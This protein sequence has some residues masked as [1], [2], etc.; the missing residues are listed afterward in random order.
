MSELWPALLFAGLGLGALWLLRRRALRMPPL[1]RRWRELLAARLTHYSKLESPLRELFERHVQEFLAGKRFYGCGGLAVSDEMR[2]LIAGM[3]C[4]L[5]L[6]P[7]ARV[8]PQLRSVL[9]YPTAFWVRHEE[10]DDIGLVYDEDILQVGESQEWGRVVLSWEDVQAALAG[11]AV[12]V[13]AHE[14]AH[15]LDEGEG[16]PA[17]S[18]YHRW[19]QV[20]K[21]AYGELC[22]KGSPVL[23]D[24]GAQ[25]PAEF[26]ALATE[27]YF[28]RG[29]E[30]RKHHTALYALLKEFYLL[31]TA[32]AS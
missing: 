23:D 22:E 11:D 14:F 28:Q 8:F 15:Q 13:V 17:L 29:A 31:D 5:L 30:L 24:Y 6:R 4:L 19:S 9:L 16:A 1:P 2:V 21:D 10:P 20:M 3:A 18:E 12:N 26:F 7:G 32:G 27:S 25:G